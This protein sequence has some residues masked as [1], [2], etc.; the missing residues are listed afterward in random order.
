MLSNKWSERKNYN[1][2]QE[3]KSRNSPLILITNK[4]IKNIDNVI[5]IPYNKTFNNLL[6]IIPIQF[7]SYFLSISKNINPDRPKNLAK[8]VTVE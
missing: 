3:V 6:S 5:K 8:C 7:A 1:T 2:Y 4:D